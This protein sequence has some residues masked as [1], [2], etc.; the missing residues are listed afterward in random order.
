LLEK[1]RVRPFSGKRDDEAMR[2]AG[3]PLA[4]TSLSALA[5]GNLSEEKWIVDYGVKKKSRGLDKRQFI[6]NFVNSRV[7]V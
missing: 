1:R 2:W 6:G 5:A 4:Y 3:H 7:V